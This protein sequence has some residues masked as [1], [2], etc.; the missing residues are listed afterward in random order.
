VEADGGDQPVDLAAVDGEGDVGFEG[1]EGC[2]LDLEELAG[3]V[4][5]GDDACEEDGEVDQADYD[6]EGEGFDDGAEGGDQEV[7]VGLLSGV[8]YGALTG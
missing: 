2:G 3:A 4:E 7:A 1:V 5:A 6:G 8:L